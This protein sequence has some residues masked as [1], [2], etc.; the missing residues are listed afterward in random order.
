MR[1]RSDIFQ[2]LRLPRLSLLFLAFLSLAALLA[3]VS[4]QAQ[5]LAAPASTQVAPRV[6]AKPGKDPK[7]PLPPQAS[8]LGPAQRLAENLETETL[9]L[10]SSH[11]GQSAAVTL[12]RG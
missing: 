1:A 12:E 7:P 10:L 8:V 11:P 5:T 9:A 4:P 3:A 2:S 6:K